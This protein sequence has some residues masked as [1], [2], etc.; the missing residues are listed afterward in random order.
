VKLFI[1][2]ATGKTGSA[3]VESALRDGHSVTA[4]VRSPEKMAA[5]ERLSVV[6]GSPADVDAMARAMAGHDAVF[7]TLAPGV[8][9]ILSRPTKRSWTMAAYA[10]NIVVA[11][12]RAGVKRLLAFSSAGLFPGQSLFV[13]AL[14]FPARHHMADLRA[15]EEVISSSP[16]EWTVARPNWMS[17]GEGAEYRAATDALPATPRPMT[18]HGLGRF[19]LD[20]A[21]DGRH[22]R[23]TVGLA[24]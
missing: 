1:L 14:S 9:E 7:S 3:L 23:Q 21:V 20:A 18:F 24:K 2:G 22:L 11:M 10:A 5:R 6:K 8:R 19:L 4:F 15:M 17:R 12:E 16:M 13:R